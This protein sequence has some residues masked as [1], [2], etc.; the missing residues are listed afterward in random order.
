MPYSPSGTAK[1]PKLA[2]STTSAPAR[3]IA[4]CMSV[5]TSGRVATSSSLQPSNSGPPK[6]SA[7][8]PSSWTKVPNAP[9]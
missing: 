8:S 1:A 4:S 9:S 6:S 5:I 7:V 2:V 3:N